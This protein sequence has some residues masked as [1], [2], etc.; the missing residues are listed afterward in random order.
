MISFF[1]MSDLAQLR[2]VVVMGVAGAGKSLIGEML[3]TRLGGLFEDGDDFH[4]P[5]NKEKMSAKVPLT[6]EDRQPWLEAMRRRMVEVREE[7][8]GVY[9]LACSALKGRY[10]EVLSGDDEEG[11]LRVVYL[12]GSKELIGSRMVARQGHF[13]PTA[14]LDSQFATLEEPEVGEAL[15]VG[16]EGT[17]EAIVEEIVGRLGF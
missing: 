12:K 13:M 14:L 2:T 9:V 4:P 8:V 11:V 7:G 1:V 3:A 10:R 15:V 6:D 17:P 16:V 5:A